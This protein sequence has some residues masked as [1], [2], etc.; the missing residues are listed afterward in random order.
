MFVCATHQ[1]V[2]VFVCVTHSRSGGVQ[3]AR[4]QRRHQQAAEGEGALG[5]SDQ[6]TRRARLQGTTAFSKRLS[7]VAYL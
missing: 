4:P 2:T 1:R 6:G 7:H 3:V 5:G